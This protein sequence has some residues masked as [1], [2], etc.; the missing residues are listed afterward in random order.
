MRS[1]TLPL[2]SAAIFFTLGVAACGDPKG[3]SEGESATEGE[4]A[5]EGT[6]SVGETTTGGGESTTDGSAGETTTTE[7]TTGDDTTTTGDEPPPYDGEPL[8]PADDGVW[9]WVDFPEARCRDGSSTGI[10]V[11][12]GL[13][14]KVMIYFE[15]GG[16]CFNNLSCS[17]NP[18]SYDNGNFEGW[19]DSGGRSGIFAADNPDNP[20]GEWSAIYIPYCTGD[21]H[22]G[23]NVD[24]TL[25][26]VG[27]AQ[28]FVGYSNVDAFLDRIYPTFKDAEHVLVTGVSAGGFGAAFNFDRMA[29]TFKG[30]VTLIDDSGPPMGDDYLAPCL[31]KKWRD[32]WGIDDNIDPA[33]S[34][35]SL[36]DGGGMI[37]LVSFIGEKHSDSVLALISSEEDNT[38]RTFYGFGANECN[39]L[40][41]TMSGA[42]Y[43]EG[44]YHLRDTVFKAGGGNWGSYVISGEKHTWIGDNGLYSTEVG[45]ALLIDWIT[46]ILVRDPQHVAP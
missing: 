11:R 37:N 32:A 43:K 40:F 26:D 1:T 28:Q 15:G 31:Q 5:T 23:S 13:E 34:D 12:Y 4:A 41:P 3:E 29:E 35:C 9:T 20:V 42:L 38:I 33:C 25:P 14:N 8:P 45:G 19:K 30:E 18:S 22:S 6:S 39:T 17:L 21:V 27:G 16:A 7:G 10:G 24:V 44:L 36:A 46:D 2:T